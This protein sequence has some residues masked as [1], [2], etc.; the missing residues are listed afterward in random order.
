MVLPIQLK[1]SLANMGLFRKAVSRALDPEMREEPG[2][3]LANRLVMLLIAFSILVAIVETEL[4]ITGGNEL[5]FNAIQFG[6]FVLFTVEYLARLYAAGLNPRHSSA[7]HYA[8][9]PAAILDLIVLATF[10]LPAVGLEGTMLRM[11]RAARL[12]RLARLGR[13]SRAFNR[14]AD[15]LRERRHELVVSVFAALS[16][17]M[18]SATA[19]YLI[20]GETQPE[21]FGSIPRAMWW[22]VATLTTVGYGDSVPITGLGRVVG[23]VSALTGI[24]LIAIPTGILASAFSNALQRERGDDQ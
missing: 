15:A 23:A 6:L 19:L 9:T 3:S 16:L 13:F 8:V 1:K 11:V 24:G 21:A 4:A 12:I 17:M 7:L 20:E 18:L 14:I 22:S 2:L 5:A 10:A